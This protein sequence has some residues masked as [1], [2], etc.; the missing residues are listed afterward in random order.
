MKKDEFDAKIKQDLSNK[1]QL[2]IESEYALFSQAESLLAVR[3]EHI[4]SRETIARR[5]DHAKKRRLIVSRQ[6]GLHLLELLAIHP[7]TPAMATTF[8]AL[9][10]TFWAL[11]GRNE[12]VL[13][14]SYSGLPELPKMNDF[15]ARYDA[16]VFAERQAYEREVEDA[17]RKTSGGT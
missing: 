12:S 1:T 3:R 13:R 7:D 4:A 8:I 5:A 9:V 17:H 2:S 16:Q 14:A 15:P 10:L 11:Q 6:K